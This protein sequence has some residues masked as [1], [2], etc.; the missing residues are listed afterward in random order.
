MTTEEDLESPG[1]EN[2]RVEIAEGV[3]CVALH[4]PSKM[5]ALD[6]ALLEELEA[7]MAMVEVDPD[8]GAIVLTGSPE[9]KKPSFAA[10]ADIGE[11]AEMD[12]LALREHGRYGQSVCHG[13]E[14]LRKPVIA[15]IN[16]F[17]L[18]GGL[19]IAMSCHMRFAAAGA[20][21]GQPEINLGI[22]PGFGGTQRLTRLVGRGRALEMILGGDP[23][24]AEE[25]L[26]IGLVN[27]VI[28]DQ[29]LMAETLAFARKLA[30]TAPIAR[31][32]ILEAVM[33]GADTSL[34]EGLMTEADL[35]GMLGATLDTSEGL[36][37]FIE[38]RSPEWKGC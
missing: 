19:E 21:M 20:R 5:N 32:F 25:A 37:A 10:G 36:H 11:M 2:I 22:I 23:I 15:A 29:E 14:H 31:E 38:K 28:P 18:G 24:T 1:F 27:R 12:M 6:T 33:R 26:R 13:I 17:A 8:V 9:T 16:G 7:A 30:K 35:F 34:E 3:A 4:R